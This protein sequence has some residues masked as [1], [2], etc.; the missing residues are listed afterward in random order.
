VTLYPNPAD[1]EVRIQLAP[2][3]SY[4][5]TTITVYNSEGIAVKEL[6]PGELLQTGELPNGIYYVTALSGNMFGVQKL[7]VQH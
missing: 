4:T 7:L 6:K 5:S 1:K 3:W 2:L